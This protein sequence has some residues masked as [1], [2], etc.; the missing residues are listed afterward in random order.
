M[1]PTGHVMSRRNRKY[2]SMGGNGQ[3]T[4]HGSF[5]VKV[6]WGEQTELTGRFVFVNRQVFWTHCAFRINRLTLAHSRLAR[7]CPT[8]TQVIH[9][10]VGRDE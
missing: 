1:W 6:G 5:V 8:L 3:L 9:E 10:F 4:P 2:I 7:D